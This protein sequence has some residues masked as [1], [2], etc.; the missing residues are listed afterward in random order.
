ML[1]DDRFDLR[2]FGV[3]GKAIH[4]P[5]HTPSSI[6]VILDSGGVIIGGG[7][8]IGCTHQLPMFAR[9][10]PRAKESLRWVASFEPTKIY[11]AH[12]GFLEP[13]MVGKM[14]K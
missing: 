10:F 1:I 5:G 6:S 4:T 8:S 13:E 9:D 7:S 12:G 3:K 11:S 14:L 2:D